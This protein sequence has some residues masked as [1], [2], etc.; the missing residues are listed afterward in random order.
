MSV[1]Q[2]Q[3]AHRGALLT[4]LRRLHFYIGCSSARLFSSLHLPV[5]Y[6]C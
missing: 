6:M 4:L 2:T 1:N 3:L 5:P